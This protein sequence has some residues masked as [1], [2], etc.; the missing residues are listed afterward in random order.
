MRLNDETWS[1]L[2][3]GLNSGLIDVINQNIIETFSDAGKD[4][5]VVKIYSSNIEKDPT[6]FYNTVLN[7]SLFSQYHVII[8]K[9]SS[10]KIATNMLKL[11]TMA[12]QSG[13]DIKKNSFI[14]LNADP[15]DA[16]SKL[17]SLYEKELNIF[18]VPCYDDDKNTTITVIKDFF[19]KNGISYDSDLVNKISLYSTGNRG[20]LINDLSIFLLYLGDRKEF[21]IE[22]VESV[23]YDSTSAVMDELIDAVF[24]GTVN[25]ADI[26]LYK[27]VNSG[28]QITTVVR[29]MVNHLN[30]VR[31]IKESILK[32]SSESYAIQS[33]RVFFKRIENYKRCLSFPIEVIDLILYKL[34]NLEINVK[35]NSKYEDHCLAMVN[36]MISWIC[37]IVKPLR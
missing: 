33:S 11:F 28:S 24:N 34:A 8:I 13:V 30:T 14:I 5:K 15:L 16:K 36:Q 19:G 26:A 22:D 25:D 31:S 3:Y 1:C 27:I 6:D 12:Q 35:R 2:L 17:R 23:F 9:E 7:M 18:S 29:G 32:G 20:E 10:N 37:N 4:C 21:N